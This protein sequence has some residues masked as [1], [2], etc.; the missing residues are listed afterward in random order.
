MSRYMST[1]EDSAGLIPMSNIPG[2]PAQERIGELTG[3]W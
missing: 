3:H 2:S 1:A